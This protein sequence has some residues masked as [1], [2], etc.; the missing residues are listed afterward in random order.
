[1]PVLTIEHISPAALQSLRELARIRGKPEGEVAGELL[2]LA[3]QS[4][5]RKRGAAALR[6]RQ[7]TPSDV[8]QTDSVEIIRSLRDD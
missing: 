4:E 3:L 2:E 7:L 8:K 6:V 5:P 1:M